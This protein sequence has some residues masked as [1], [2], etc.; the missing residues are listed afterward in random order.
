MNDIELV[1]STKD[2]FTVRISGETFRNL[3]KYADFLKAHEV[4]GGEGPFGDSLS[5]DD[6]TFMAGIGF[7]GEDAR[8]N[9][10]TYL[11]GFDFTGGKPE[12]ESIRADLD[13]LAFEGW[14]GEAKA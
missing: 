8:Y 7:R 9:A 3:R 4:R 1:G 11:D 12:E 14:R 10:E 6:C 5:T 2:S 13:K